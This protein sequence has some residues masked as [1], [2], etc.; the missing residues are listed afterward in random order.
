M[1]IEQD[2]KELQVLELSDK[3]N[4]LIFK[5]LL[6]IL[7][8]S[9]AMIVVLPISLIISILI[10]L[11]SKGPVIYKQKRLGQD[12]KLFTIYKFRTMVCNAEEVMKNFT[13]EQKEEFEKH[14]KLKNDPR[15]TKMGN[16]LRKTS[17]DELP[18]L[19]N[20]L[21]GDMSII[22]PRPVVENEIEKYGFFKNK[23]LSIKPGLTGWW[24]CNGRSST[25]YNERISL[26]IYYIDNISLKLDIKCFFKTILSIIKK[27]GAM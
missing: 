8:T 18:Q 3:P 22:G 4:Y 25:T 27:D 6:D 11:D 10:R 12:G 1:N 14:F 13:P 16:F 5:R 15:I 23:Y 21:K 2:L 24:A 9:L 26:E 20:I 7:L 19:I 17:L